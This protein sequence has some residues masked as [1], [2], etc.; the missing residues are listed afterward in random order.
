MSNQ[1]IK[2]VAATFQTRE[3]AD[4]AVEHIVQK[5]GFDRVDIFLQAAGQ[6]NSS[7]KTQSG[8]ETAS[9]DHGRMMDVTLGGEIVVSV[10]ARSDQVP[11]LHRGDAGAIHVATR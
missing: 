5:A 11:V 1:N 8:G 3:A 6:S 7:G 9:V 2:T 4:L 10:D